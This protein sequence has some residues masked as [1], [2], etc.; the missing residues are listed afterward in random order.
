LKEKVSDVVIVSK[1]YTVKQ[2]DK[3]NRK[4][5]EKTQKIRSEFNE[6]MTSS[7]ISLKTSKLTLKNEK[8]I[9]RTK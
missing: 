6:R 2:W 9:Y 8:N 5:N 7:N 1:N 3:M 4:I